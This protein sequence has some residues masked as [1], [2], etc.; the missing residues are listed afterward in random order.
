MA[1]SAHG[2]ITVERVGTAHRHHLTEH[3]RTALDD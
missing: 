1:D 3:G 2:W